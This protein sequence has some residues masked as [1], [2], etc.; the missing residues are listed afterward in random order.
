MTKAFIFS[1]NFFL[2]IVC[3]FQPL[4]RS[5]SSLS[6]HRLLLSM[7]PPSSIAENEKGTVVV[8]GA[9]GYI[10]RYVVREGENTSSHPASWKFALV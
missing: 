3:G 5:V 4:P 9:T 6:R 8:A 1:I 10:G 2:L 7:S